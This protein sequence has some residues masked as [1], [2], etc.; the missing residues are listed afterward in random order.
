MANKVRTVHL[1]PEQGTTGH[2]SVRPTGRVR[3]PGRCA[4]GTQPETLAVFMLCVVVRVGF[5]CRHG[6]CV[7]MGGAGD[8][9]VQMKSNLRYITSPA[10]YATGAEVTLDGVA[11]EVIECERQR[12]GLYLI[13]VRRK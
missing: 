2:V 3:S 9:G 12:N 11:Y 7:D 8:M 1:L 6:Y 13:T 4:Q 10:S 5:G